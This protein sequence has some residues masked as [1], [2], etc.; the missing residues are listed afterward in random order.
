MSL[1]DISI[2]NPVFAWMLMLGLIVF[3]GIA[4][5]DLGVSQMPEVDFPVLNVSVSWEGAA[6]EVMESDVA[7]IIEDAV[8]SSQGLREVTSTTRQGSTD[9]K[10]EFTL[11]RDIDVALQ[12]VQS[13]VAQ[14]Q[15]RLP[16]D[17]DPPIVSKLNPTDQPIMWLALS[18]DRPLRDMITYVQDHLKD[19]FQTIPGVGEIIL[20]GFVD[21]NLRVWVS[22]EKLEQYQLTIG[23]IIDAIERNHSEMP[24]GRIETSDKEMNVRAMGEALTV[25]EFGDILI[26]RRGGQP[27]YKPILLKE[28]ARVEDAL[29]DQRRLSRVMGQPA[30]GLGIRKQLGANAVEVA[31]GVKDKLKEVQKDLPK[32]MKLGVNFD[33]TTFVEEAIHELIFALIL[34]AVLTAL[35]CWMFLGSWSSTF[36]ILLAIPTSIVGTFLIFG[37]MNFTLNTFT[38]LG[39]SL[40]IG[41]VVD[42]AIMVLEN[43]VRYREQGKGRVEAAQLG[44]RQITFAAIAATLALVAIFLPVAFMTGI[45][46]KFF[47]AFGVAISGAVLISLLEA[48]TLTPMRASQFLDISER[49]TRFGRGV[50]ATLT[51]LSKGYA[52]TLKLALSRPILVCVGSFVFFILSLFLFGPLRKEFVPAQDQGYFIARLQAPVGSSLPFTSEKF[53]QAE[54]MVMKM[55]EVRRYFC[56]VGGFGGGEVN[57]GVLFISMKPKGERGVRKGMRKEMSQADLMA[58]VRKE[59]GKITDIKVFIQDLS[60]RGFTAQRGFPIE[61]SIQGRDWTKLADLSRTMMEKMRATGLMTD[62]DTDYLLGVTE[63]QIRPNRLKAAERGVEMVEIGNA[64]NALIGGQR[65]GKY[66]E[67][68]RRYDVRVRLVAEDRKKADDVQNISVWNNRG[69]RVKLADVVDLELKPSLMSITRRNRERAIGVFA[70]ILPG[71]SQSEALSSVEKISEEVLPE[72][73][74]IEFTGGSASMKETVGSFWLAFIL[75]LVIAYM[76]LASQFNSYIHPITVLLAMPFAIS[77]ALIALFV[78]NQS[79]N[80][81]SAIAF[82]L[83]MGIV[84]KNSILLVEFTNHVREEKKKPVREA[85]LEACP[86]RLRPILMTSI[87]TVAAAIPAALA[88]GPGAETRIPMAVAVIGGV[89]L[90]TFLTLFVVPCAYMLFSRFEKKRAAAGFLLIYL[91]LTPPAFSAPFSEKEFELRSPGTETVVDYKK[92]G[93]FMG[94]GTKDY[95]YSITD[96]AGLK[97]AAGEGV[98]PNETCQSDPGAKNFIERHNGKFSPWDFTE[99]PNPR[100]NFYAWCLAADVDPGTKLFFTAEAL[101]KAGLIPEALKAYYAIV[102]HFPKTVIWSANGDYYW[103]VAPEAISRIRKLCASRSEIGVTLEGALVDITRAGNQKPDADEIRVWP[104]RFVKKTAPSGKALTVVKESGKGRVRAVKYN[105]GSWRLLVD[106]KNFVVKGVTYTSTKIGESP[107]DGTMRPWMT[108]DDN[109]NGLHDGLFDSW[110]DKNRDGERGD[111]EPVVGDAQLLKEMGVNTIRTYHGVDSAGNYD[112]THYDKELM[113]RLNRDYGIFFMMG[114]FAGAYTIGSKASWGSG[115]D[116]TDPTQRDRVKATVKKMVLDHKDEPYVLFWLLGNE[117]QHPHTNTNAF[118]KPAAYAT[119]INEIAEMIHKIDPEH[120]VAICNLNT[121]GLKELARYAPAVDI[122]GANVYSGAY[123]M[124]SIWQLVKAYYDRPIVFTEM[125]CDAYAT[126]VGLDEA[127]Q[128]DYFSKNWEDIA[129]NLGDGP[130]EGNGIGTVIFEWMDEWWKSSHGYPQGSPNSHDTRGD[131]SNAPYPDKWSNEEWCGIMGQGDGKSSPYLREIREVYHT[132]KRA[133]TGGDK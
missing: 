54:Q 66:T 60:M 95:R 110:V 31:H 1:S 109:Q 103:Y 23:D 120:P 15:Q 125:G 70:N 49:R 86:I 35:V 92:Y 37:F 88:F 100:D 116:Y 118:Q 18:G 47:F 127:A 16:R 44:A 85:L 80:L 131:D 83:L 94:S 72:G 111:D 41:I 52:R 33:S 11:D 84:K 40:A 20:G 82:I 48:L 126:G 124:G 8:M 39:L 119:L 28:V 34:A 130:G 87:A 89:V 107:H 7:D 112:P 25:E 53:E 91:F 42:D 38:V 67:G 105:D 114:D 129:M 121:T 22:S 73:Y 78:S 132:A 50:E 43:I 45:I 102:V 14:A 29:A 61:F 9:V 115:T 46:G 32:G 65:V 17:I 69:E 59:L 71:K 19:R 123:S 133:W 27:V 57:T 13:R 10:L 79:I 2:K 106:G 58:D 4:Y 104:G 6:P 122:Y 108:L 113:R 55:P 81:Y 77:G 76:I 62:V 64:V 12:E 75:G 101:R 93:R 26:S 63:V 74:R 97:A 3:G 117:N 30:I 36:N 98:Y 90:S 5:K 24:A 96:E 56:S 68:G 21:R 128:A 51:N 99:G